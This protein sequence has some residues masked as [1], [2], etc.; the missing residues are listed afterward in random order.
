M[1]YNIENNNENVRL[2]NNSNLFINKFDYIYDIEY[3]INIR[4]IFLNKINS[5][6]T[7][8]ITNNVLDFTLNTNNFITDDKKEFNF[9]NLLLVDENINKELFNFK[10][11]IKSINTEYFNLNLKN[12]SIFFN[13]YND[14]QIIIN[15]NLYNYSYSNLNNNIEFNLECNI[16]T[17]I[18]D[19]ILEYN[20]NI[21]LINNKKLYIYN[22][23]NKNLKNIDIDI[24][25]N[26]KLI[27]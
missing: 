10:Y 9:S 27:K 12:E 15:I 16:N 8:Y 21:Y 22:I 11:I 24:N 17:N 23:N 5:R 2:L 25:N 7:F 20:N 19:G 13:Y 18:N 6:L 4:A 14:T 3:I 1:D 26:L